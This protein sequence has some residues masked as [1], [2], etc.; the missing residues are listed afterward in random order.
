MEEEKSLKDE[1]KEL[2]E[3]ITKDTETK[4]KEKVKKFRVP[5]KGRVNRVKLKNNWIT[6]LQVYENKTAKF[7]KAKIQ[8][9]TIMIDGI[10]RLATADNVLLIEG[11]QKKP[12]VILPMWSVKPTSP[13]DQQFLSISKNYE[14]IKDKGLNINGYKILL[15]RM[16]SEAISTKKPIP[17]WIWVGGLAVVGI[18]VYIMMSQK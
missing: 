4:K 16:K 2:K 14:E 12:M 13:S 1:I 10:P 9:Q 6:V 8:E 3:A 11:R 5:F 7:T 15:N 18:V 17:W